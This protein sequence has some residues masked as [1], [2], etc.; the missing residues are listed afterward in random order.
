MAE[1][2]VE[3]AQTE[4]YLRHHGFVTK[5]PFNLENVI[6]VM[7][8]HMTSEIAHCQATPLWWAAQ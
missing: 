1:P 8:G 4:A 3:H 5:Q 6:D 7:S 2:V